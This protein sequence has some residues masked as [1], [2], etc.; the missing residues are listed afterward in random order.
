V[1]REIALDEIQSLLTRYFPSTAAR[2]KDQ[3]GTAQD[4]FHASW[5][6]MEKLMPLID[7]RAGYDSLHV[8]LEGE[9]SKY[10]YVREPVPEMNDSLPDFGA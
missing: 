7:L 8:A 6:E 3:A 9:K 4:A 5:T 1:H 10:S 2:E